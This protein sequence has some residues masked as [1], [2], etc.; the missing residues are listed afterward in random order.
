MHVKVVVSMKAHNIIICW[1]VNNVEEND[2]TQVLIYQQNVS[3][4]SSDSVAFNSSDI[5][6]DSFE[7]QRVRGI[8]LRF[9]LWTEDSD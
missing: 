6:C 9:S 5:F 1:S 3:K 4:G 2:N 7:N 8:E